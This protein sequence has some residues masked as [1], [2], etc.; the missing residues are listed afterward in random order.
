MSM[1]PC[2]VASTRVSAACSYPGFLSLATR[3]VR[4]QQT[5][6]AA[7]TI[8]SDAPNPAALVLPSRRAISPISK[9]G[10][11]PKCLLQV[12]WCCPHRAM[13][14]RRVPGSGVDVPGSASQ[15]MWL[16]D[17]LAQTTIT[18]LRVCDGKHT[19]STDWLHPQ[20]PGLA[21]FLNGNIRSGPRALH[22]IKCS[23]CSCR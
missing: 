21:I 13:G 17:I 22:L 9:I 12:Q 5:S 6:E 3:I 1:A 8:Y 2:A 4:P 7:R 14:L 16:F 19:V 10:A 11:C 23:L 15:L 18:G 20:P